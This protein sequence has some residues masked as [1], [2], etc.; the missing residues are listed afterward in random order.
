MQYPR[1]LQ[2]VEDMSSSLGILITSIVSIIPKF[3]YAQNDEHIARLDEM[4][5]TGKLKIEYKNILLEIEELATKAYDL[6]L[7]SGSGW[8]IDKNHNI[9]DVYEI[10]DMEDN[11]L[12][13]SLAET[14]TYLQN[15]IADYYK[16]I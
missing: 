7:I 10:F 12:Y 3:M 8:G 11:I 15:S 1:L 9:I 2:E 13:L 5:R 6:R 4:V 16:N 14:R